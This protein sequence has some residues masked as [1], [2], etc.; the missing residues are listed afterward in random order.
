[1]EIDDFGGGIEE[2]IMKN[3]KEETWWVKFV[4][5]SGLIRTWIKEWNDNCGASWSNIKMCSHGTKRNSDVTTLGSISST[6][7]DS[8]LVR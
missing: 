3:P 2:R 4:R 7:K 1:M 5:R 8:H 6:H